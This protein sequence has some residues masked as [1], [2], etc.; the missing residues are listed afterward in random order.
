[1]LYH[2]ISIFSS[3]TLGY[4]LILGGFTF[5]VIL[6]F[7]FGATAPIRWLVALFLLAEGYM[8]SSS[9]ACTSA[10]LFMRAE[11]TA[12]ACTNEKYTTYLNANFGLD[13]WYIQTLYVGL[14]V[15]LIWPFIRNI[16]DRYVLMKMEKQAKIQ[17]L[18]V[19]EQNAVWLKETAHR[20]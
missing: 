20:Q 4:Y 6:S 12:R 19:D 13:I 5:W 11:G 9:F 15:F 3:L 1:M 18:E 14:L 16:R 17:M 8:M 2:L 7:I 10:Y